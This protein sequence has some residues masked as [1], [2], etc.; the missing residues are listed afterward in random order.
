VSALPVGIH[1]EEIEEAPMDQ[2][3]LVVAASFLLLVAILSGTL[4][5]FPISRRLAE[6]LH[7][8]IEEKKEGAAL[9]AREARRLQEKVAAL[10]EQF[11]TLEEKHRF[12]EGLLEDGRS[13]EPLPSE[14]TRTR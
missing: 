3:L 14:R 8:Q 2:D 9:N 6:F 13:A 11:A 5:F 4:L 12:L 7:W 1:A 10:E